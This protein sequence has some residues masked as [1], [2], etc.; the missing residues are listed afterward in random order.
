[1]QNS[2]TLKAQKSVA[3]PSLAKNLH[4]RFAHVIQ[5]VLCVL[6]MFT[7]WKETYLSAKPIS[8]KALI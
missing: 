4:Y 2:S 1:M 7:R 5:T 8:A 3:K 6:P